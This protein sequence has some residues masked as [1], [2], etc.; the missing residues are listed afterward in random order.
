VLGWFAQ[1]GVEY[2]RAYPSTLIGDEPDDLFEPA[3]DNWGFEAWFA[4]WTG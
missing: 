1:N 2:V 3:T 4:R